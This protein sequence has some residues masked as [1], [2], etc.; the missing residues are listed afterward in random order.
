MNNENYFP[1]IFKLVQCSFSQTFNLNVLEKKT[2]FQQEVTLDEEEH[3]VAVHVPAHNDVD[4]T[5][6]ITDT[7]K[8]SDTHASYPE[9]AQ[10]QHLQ[11]LSWRKW[12]PDRSS[13]VLDLLLK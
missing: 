8:V 2:E 7:T 4:E 9:I 5:Y 10:G 12:R 6:F 1:T 13:I 11:K 3:I